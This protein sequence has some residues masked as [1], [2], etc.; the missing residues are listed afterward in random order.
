MPIKRLAA[1]VLVLTIV[2]AAVAWTAAQPKQ[3][4]RLSA[5]DFVE[6][7][8]LYTYYAEGVD[9]GTD[10]PAWTFT[11]DGTFETRAPGRHDVP[12]NPR[13]GRKALEET[14]G[15]LA[16]SNQVNKTRHVVTNVSARAAAGGA[17]ASAYMFTLD[18][19]DSTKPAVVTQYGRYDD[20][21]VKTRNGWRF[22]SRLFY[23]DLSQPLTTPAVPPVPR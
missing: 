13:K 10:N 1:P 14:Y 3:V 8:Q 11:D 21:L 5:E 4:G 15:N 19:R 9:L 16:K 17:K 12:G 20:T 2:L 18:G 7:Y 22:K 6:I 23:F